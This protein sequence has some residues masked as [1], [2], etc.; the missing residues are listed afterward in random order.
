MSQLL[1][2]YLGFASKHFWP[3]A[4]GC[5]V[6][7]YLYYFHLYRRDGAWRFFDFKATQYAVNYLEHGFV[8][9]GLVGTVFF[10]VE[11]EHV[12]SLMIGLTTVFF[13][14]L[15]RAIDTQVCA[16]RESTGGEVVRALLA[17][18]PFG[19]FQ[20]SFD[21]GRYD[22]INL[23]L[24]VA[25]LFGIA[26]GRI[27]LASVLASIGV[28][29]HEAFVVYGLPLILALQYSRMRAVPGRPRAVPE[30]AAIALL[31]TG[32]VACAL[33][34][35]VLGN[36]AAVTRLRYGTGQEVWERGLFEVSFGETPLE[37][38]V[39]V[40]VLASLYGWLAA[41]YRRNKGG[42]DVF[43]LASLAPLGLFLL[44]VDCA[45]WTALCFM[46]ILVVVLIKIQLQGWTLE[47][48]SLRYGMFLA[49]LPWGPIGI[50][51]LFPLVQRAVVHAF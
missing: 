39:L 9:R 40:L 15:F 6:I 41:F 34:I 49:L 7:S 4:I 45:R 14:L 1:D 31:I 2:R 24:L 44:G 35:V 3:L 16:R 27:A 43:A 23:Y 19:A 10:F 25:A 5:H 11:H 22:V 42:F 8:K 33:A 46:T 26:H 29:V 13:V 17:T 32:P 38:V 47:A 48:R 50:T 51:D 37:A 18:S 21:A 12:R 30:L 20:L 36:S 28:L